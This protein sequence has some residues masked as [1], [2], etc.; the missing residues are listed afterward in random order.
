M[1][2]PLPISPAEMVKVAQY[3]RRYITPKEEAAIEQVDAKAA[4]QDKHLSIHI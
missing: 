3:V 4:N 2:L 1:G